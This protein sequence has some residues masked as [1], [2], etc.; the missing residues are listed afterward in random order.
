MSSINSVPKVEGIFEPLKYS[1]TP[2]RPYF[3][4]QHDLY[5]GSPNPSSDWRVLLHID[6]IDD[7]RKM[8]QKTT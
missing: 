3:L 4:A 8:T 6:I 5:R 7:S 1:L 2:F